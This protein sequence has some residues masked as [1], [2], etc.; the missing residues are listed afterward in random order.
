VSAD[1]V[2][3]YLGKQHEVS[4]EI[5]VSKSAQRCGIGNILAQQ[6]VSI[7]AAFSMQKIMLTVFKGST[8]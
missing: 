7:G 1:L 5:Q 4:Y 3:E 2:W 8:L 6:L